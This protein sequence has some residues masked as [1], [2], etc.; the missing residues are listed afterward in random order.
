MPSRPPGTAVNGLVTGDPRNRRRGQTLP[1]SSL[2]KRPQSRARQAVEAGETLYLPLHHDSVV[3][4]VVVEVS[5]AGGLGVASERART[6]WSEAVADTA[7][8]TP[9]RPRH[10]DLALTFSLPVPRS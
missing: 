10:P 9:H 6:A 7:H 1:G 5:A 2:W 4:V 8:G 3:S